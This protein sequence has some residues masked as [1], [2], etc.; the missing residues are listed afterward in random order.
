MKTQGRRE[1]VAIQ[2]GKEKGLRAYMLG[3]LLAG[4]FLLISISS[5][6]HCDSYDGPVIKD[7]LKALDQNKVELVLKWIEPQQ[8]KE[9]ISLFDK[10]YKLKK[11]IGRASCRERV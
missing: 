2:T 3:L 6:A 4:A 1:T 9:V 11:E 5:F 10:T 8:E 7:A